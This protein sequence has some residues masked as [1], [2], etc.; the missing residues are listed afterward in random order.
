MVHEAVPGEHVE[1]VE[2]PVLGK[3][4][5]VHGR[6]DGPSL[7]EDRQGRQH[8][9]L[10]VLQQSDAPLDG[11]AEGALA[12]G[13]ID[14]PGTQGVETT[15]EPGEQCSRIQQPAA[16]RRELDGE[17]QTVEA[18]A[19]LRDGHRVVLGQ[20]EVVADGL[21]SIDEEPHGGQCGQLFHAGSMRERRHRER[22]DRVLPLGPEPESGA[23]RH[24]DRE[25][26]ATREE[27]VEVGCDADDLFEVV[28]HEQRRRVREVLDQDVQGRAGTVDGGA[29]D[30]CDA[31]QHQRRFDDRRQRDEHRS[32]RVAV[33]QSFRHGDREPRLA[34]ATGAGQGDQPDLGRLQQRRDVDD[35]L[36]PPD[37][38]R[39]R[40]RQ[41]PRARP[42]RRRGR[43]RIV[44]A[45]PADVNRSLRSR[46]RSS[47]TRRASSRGVR[48]G[49]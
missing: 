21:G 20:G 12:L 49:R 24:E 27:P 7:D 44:D 45:R 42:V 15:S 6:F 9:L 32:A 29:D 28:Q 1:Q 14:R 33:L 37:Q 18:P 2:R 38:R 26:G 43:H 30:G 35:V 36:L 5:D 31:R 40:H 23:A 10:G 16:R 13:Q 25:P 47:R 41:G 48:N 3:T 39:R 8:L 17:R 46:A 11:R 4:G 34:D 22:A 19:D